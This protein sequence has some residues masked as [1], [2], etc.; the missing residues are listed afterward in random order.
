M[1]IIE[2]KSRQIKGWRLRAWYAFVT[3]RCW[4][5]HNVLGWNRWV[6]NV[7]QPN[8]GMASIPGRTRLGAWWRL[9]RDRNSMGYYV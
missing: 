2:P 9:L 7:L 1:A 4:E 3:P 6:L 5:R 8:G